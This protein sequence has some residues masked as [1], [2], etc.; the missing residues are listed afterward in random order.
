MQ[1]CNESVQILLLASMYSGYRRKMQQTPTALIKRL[2]D[3]VNGLVVGKAV[4]FQ[5][6]YELV[7]W[8]I[9][10]IE[11]KFGHSYCLGIPVG[12]TKIDG[13]DGILR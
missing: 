12:A 13:P 5:V 1:M 3:T 4:V 2:V 10:A 9:S 8:D 7:A 11:I 6:S